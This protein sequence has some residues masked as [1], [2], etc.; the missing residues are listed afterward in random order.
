MRS[1]AYAG[2]RESAAVTMDRAWMDPL[3]FQR[4]LI[5]GLLLAFAVAAWAVLVWKSAG[6]DM[7]MHA[8]TMGM[9][10]PPFLAMWVVMMVGMMFPAA[11]PVILAFNKVQSGKRRRGEAFVS[12]W[13]SAA[14]I[15]LI[16]YGAAVVLVPQVLPTF[17]AAGHTA[18][19]AGYGDG[20]E[21]AT[22]GR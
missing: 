15:A 10:A 11:A 20:R 14:A 2:S 7:R 9:T 18:M 4:N 13:V 8:R 16:A 6:A 22:P 5:L 21:G 12:T 3:R 19:P 17:P 1:N